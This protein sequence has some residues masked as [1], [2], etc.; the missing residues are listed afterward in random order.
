MLV[1]HAPN[2]IEPAE[3]GMQREEM[4]S[5]ALRAALALRLAAPATSWATASAAAQRSVAPA[6]SGAVQSGSDAIAA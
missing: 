4:P 2:F 1:G 5:Y 6:G 3:A